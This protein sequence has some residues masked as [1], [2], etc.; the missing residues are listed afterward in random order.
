MFIYS[1]QVSA[2]CGDAVGFIMYSGTGLQV[3]ANRT[4]LMMS[5]MYLCLYDT[6]M[7][8]Q[9]TKLH[10]SALTYCSVIDPPQQSWP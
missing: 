4:A 8:L 6:W 9:Q 5:L 1:Q 10:I 2:V 7:K 3:S